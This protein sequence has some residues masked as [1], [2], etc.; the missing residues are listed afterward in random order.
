MEFARDL[1]GSTYALDNRVDYADSYGK[2]GQEHWP[3][4]NESIQ[5]L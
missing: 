1:S 5:A 3:S 4:E 2:N